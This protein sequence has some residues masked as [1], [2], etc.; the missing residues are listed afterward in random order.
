MI[1][2]TQQCVAEMKLSKASGIEKRMYG[3]KGD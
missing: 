3:R 1:K 2:K